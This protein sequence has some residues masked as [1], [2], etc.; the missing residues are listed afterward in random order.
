MLSETWQYLPITLAEIQSSKC[1]MLQESIIKGFE[2][3]MSFKPA[4]CINLFL[5]IFLFLKSFENFSHWM[6][7][8]T[9]FSSALPALFDTNVLLQM[10]GRNHCLR[11]DETYSAIKNQTYFH[12]GLS[13]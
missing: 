13:L 9:F 3:V 6:T 8:L 10:T 12:S 2:A 7:N 5:F 1:L 11:A 4:L